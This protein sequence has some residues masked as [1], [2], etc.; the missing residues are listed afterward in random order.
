MTNQDAPETLDQDAMESIHSGDL[1]RLRQSFSDMHPAEIA[2]LIETLSPGEREIAWA[3]IATDR[4]GDVLVELSDSVRDGFVKNM[5]LA[6]L[7]ATTAGLDPDDVADLVGDLPGD[8]A[9]GLLNALDQQNRK[10]LEH[11]LSYPDGTAGSLMTTQAIT[12]RGDI[13]LDVVLRYLRLLGDIPEATDKLMVVDRQDGFQGVLPVTTLLTHALDTKVADVLESDPVVVS[14]QM[15]AQDV[16]SLFE[17]RDLISAPVVTAD[18]RFVGRIT[19][20]DI[21][22]VLRESA[23]QSFMGMAGL[24]KDEELFAPVLTSARRRTLWLG[25]NLLT[26]IL[27]SWVIGLFGATLEKMVALAILMPIVASMGGNAGNQTLALVIRGMAL[28]QISQRNALRLLRKELRV[29]ALNG[30]IWALVVGAVVTLWFGNYLLGL[31]IGTA[32]IANLLFAAFSGLAVPIALRWLGIDPAIA[33][34]VLLTTI[35]DVMGFLIFLG[36]A[37]LVLV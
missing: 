4:Q 33:S 36:L 2:H 25:V 11:L 17:K 37:S 22:D 29:G 28:H 12:V 31:V 3:A 35:T 16:A 5:G 26:A 30:L 27:A 20:D 10:R 1:Q 18:G 21:V 14:D 6:E 23:D 7:L 19:I 24:N 13:T 9:A 15:P 8:R 34:S 32:M